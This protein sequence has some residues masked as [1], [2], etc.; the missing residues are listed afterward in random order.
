MDIKCGSC[1]TNYKI[2]E[3]KIP[4]TGAI[5]KCR[6]CGNKIIVKPPAKEEKKE[7]KTPEETSLHDKAKRYARVLASDAYLYN[8]RSVAEAK[9]NGNL[10]DA[11]LDEVRKSYELYKKRV[12]E[13]VLNE[14]YFFD[15][16]NKQLADGENVFNKNNVLN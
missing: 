1:G 16:F 9:A 15:A 11:M 5:L 4:A 14:N 13:K 6:K 3:N 7:I 8:E 2:N 10:F 12:D